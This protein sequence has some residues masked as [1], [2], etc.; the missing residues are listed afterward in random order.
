MT[1]LKGIWRWFAKHVLRR[2]P[3]A[4]FELQEP[5]TADYSSIEDI[6]MSRHTALSEAFA[7]LGYSAR[8]AGRALNNVPMF[9]GIDKGRPEGDETRIVVH[10]REISFDIDH[11]ELEEA[12]N[13]RTREMAQDM[14]ECY[15]SI[16]ERQITKLQMAK[17]YLLDRAERE[18]EMFDEKH[19]LLSK[20]LLGIALAHRAIQR[21]MKDT[22]VDIERLIDRRAIRISLTFDIDSIAQDMK[23]SD[24]LNTL[25]S[26]VED[27]E[28]N[29][30]TLLKGII[31]IFKKYP[32][33]INDIYDEEGKL[34]DLLKAAQSLLEQDLSCK[35][36]DLDPSLQSTATTS[37]KAG[38]RT[39]KLR[40]KSD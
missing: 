31:R 28:K 38:R 15:R 9:I 6:I 20:E 3:P 39:L 1:F 7:N 23:G 29:A 2:E 10:S 14:G 35:P 18:S 22:L 33:T 5:E 21:N 12:I 16:R 11:S 40:K 27:H 25:I 17:D 34:Q 19:G 13:R 37:R 8:D 30:K 32:S 24:S 36:V 26:N 4:P